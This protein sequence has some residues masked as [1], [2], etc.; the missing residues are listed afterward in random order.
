LYTSSAQRA[1]KIISA[2]KK[3]QKVTVYYPFQ[4]PSE[5]ILKPGINR[6][7]I[8]GILIGLVFITFGTFLLSIY[9]H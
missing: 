7:Q 8:A 2:F 1:S 5:G 4:K 6:E 9:I 3:D